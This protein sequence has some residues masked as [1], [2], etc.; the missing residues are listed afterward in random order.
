MQPVEELSD[1]INYLLD[2]HYKQYKLTNQ[3]KS[4]S[5]RFSDLI[6]HLAVKYKSKVV[7]LIDEYD[8]PILDVINNSKCAVQINYIPYYA[9]ICGYTQSEMEIS[10]EEYLTDGKVDKVKLKQWYNGYN[11]TG[12]EKQKVY[13]PFDILLF[14]NN[15]YRYKIIG[16]KP[17]R[18]HFLLNF[19]S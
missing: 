4:V 17:Q 10:F 5:S 14:C 15:D 3:Y 9:D 7:L 6:S 18:H 16:L 8:K 11:F 1:K 13:N 12:V 19:L 2:T